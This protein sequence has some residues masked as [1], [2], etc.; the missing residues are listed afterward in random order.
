MDFNALLLQKL[1]QFLYLFLE[2]PNKFGVGVLV[3]NGLADN[4]FRTI[5][6]SAEAI[7]VEILA[8]PLDMKR[9]L[10]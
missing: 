8:F 9:I 2:F 6:V 1:A 7:N 10:P 4:L 3:D 5:G